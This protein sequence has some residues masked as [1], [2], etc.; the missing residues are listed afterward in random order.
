VRS[1]VVDVKRQIARVENLSRCVGVEETLRKSRSERE[2]RIWV[3]RRDGLELG[4]IADTVGVSPS[5]V[6]EVLK[7][8]PRVPD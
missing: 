5:T 3:L 1:T 2:V 8:T 6:V 7:K 4:H